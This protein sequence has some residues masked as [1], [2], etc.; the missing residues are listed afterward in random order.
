MNMFVDNREPDW[1]KSAFPNA[2]IKQLEI[3]DIASDN[4]NTII[5]RKEI[6]DLAS[7]IIDGRYK[8]QIATLINYPAFYI[9]IGTLDDLSYY[10][11]PKTR[12]V[13]SA[14]K[15]IPIKYRIPLI[16]VKDNNR[17]IEIVKYIMEKR[18]D[19]DKDL[20]EIH[21]VKADPHLRILCSL[22]NISIKRAKIIRARYTSI[23]EAL[24]YV[25]D[26]WKL[27]GIGQ[28]IVDKCVEALECENTEVI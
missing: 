18:E 3:G 14:I 19:L 25:K 24:M 16:Q 7:S 23:S 20:I 21:K 5:E 15:H 17:F 4:M 22:P 28:G 6:N 11:K 10:N 2:T 1:I 26:W 8:N 9:V 27:D 12:I 13:A